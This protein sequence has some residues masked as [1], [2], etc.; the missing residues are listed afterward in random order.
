[1]ERRSNKQ[2]NRLYKNEAR[3]IRIRSVFHEENENEDKDE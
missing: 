1:M 2:I 3:V